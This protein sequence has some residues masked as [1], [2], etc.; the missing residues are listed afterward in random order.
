[1]TCRP[2]FE[3]PWPSCDHV[4][5]L[6]I[7][8]FSEQEVEEVVTGVTAGKGLPAEVM[9]QI[10][11]KADG[12]PLFAEELAKTVLDSGLMAEGEQRYAWLRSLRNLAIP[13]TLHDSLMARLDRLPQEKLVANVAAVIGRSFSYDLLTAV[14]ELPEGGASRALT[15]LQDA[16]LI[17]ERRHLTVSVQARSFKTPRIS[18][19]SR[20]AGVHHRSRALESVS[21]IASTQPNW[22]VTMQA[23]ASSRLCETGKLPA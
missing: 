20:A 23:G 7:K 13:T 8:R 11:A 2:E 10:V 12:V 14:A 21:V 6:R 18:R 3:A 22:R 4:T 5:D 15:R 9:S 1:V 16:D 19:N 17:Y